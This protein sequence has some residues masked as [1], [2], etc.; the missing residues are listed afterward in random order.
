R[1]GQ[2]RP[3]RVDL[4]LPGQPLPAPGRVAAAQEPL[5]AQYHGERPGAVRRHTG[6]VNCIPWLGHNVVLTVSAHTAS[7]PPRSRTPPAPRSSNRHAL[8]AL[9]TT[10][11]HGPRAWAARRTRTHRAIPAPPTPAGA[12]RLP[13]AGPCP[14]PA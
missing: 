9:R 12:S 11:A 4:G 1:G 3:R 13:R 2:A 14:T 6:P 8:I 10:S 5:L 7:P